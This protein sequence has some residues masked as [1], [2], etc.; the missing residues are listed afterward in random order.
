M[1]PKEILAAEPAELP[2]EIPFVP[3]PIITLP[4]PPPTTPIQPENKTIIT[5]YSK[6]VLYQD[7]NPNKIKLSFNPGLEKYLTQAELSKINWMN[8]L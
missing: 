6:E 2:I 3:K 7:K 5:K 1:K 8:Y 4:I